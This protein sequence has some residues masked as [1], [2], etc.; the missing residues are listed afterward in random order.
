MNRNSGIRSKDTRYFSKKDIE[1]I[2]KKEK[3]RK[4]IYNKSWSK[5]R[6]QGFVQQKSFFKES[7]IFLE[8]FCPKQNDNFSK[9]PKKNIDKRKSRTAIS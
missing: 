9:R 7:M 8:F 5:S 4:L 2:A 6:K 1:K 3:G